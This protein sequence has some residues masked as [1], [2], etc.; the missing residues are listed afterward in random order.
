MRSISKYLPLFLLAGCGVMPQQQSINS[1][2]HTLS[3]GQIYIYGECHSDKDCLDR[4]L[5]L[6]KSFYQQGMRHLFI[7]ASFFRAEWLNEWMKKA[8]DD[9]LIQIHEDGKGTLNYS[10]NVCI[11]YQK[12]KEQ[13][14]ETVFHGFD[15]GH[16]YDTTGKRYLNHLA[17][18]GQSNSEAYRRVQE[19]IEQ[20]RRYY[21]SK[22]K[23]DDFYREEVMTQNFIKDFE[24]LNGESIM[25]ITG[26]LHLDCQGIDNYLDRSS[27]P[28]FCYSLLRRLK[29]YYGNAIHAENLTIP[30]GFTKK[31]IVHK[32]GLDFDAFYFGTYSLP[33]Y[34]A[35][36]FWQLG[37]AMAGFRNV[38]NTKEYLNGAQFPMKL[39]ENEIY[40]LKCTKSDDSVEELYYRSSYDVSKEKIV[41]YRLKIEP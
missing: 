12:I 3:R 25:A 31:S 1:T 37:G 4:E 16:Q 26:S 5:S 2:V 40:L 30:T 11:F 21:Q 23:S 6:W 13:C 15:V 38:P 20:G 24:A 18:L 39:Y 32:Y 8:N 28:R 27:D 29:E 19:N 41:A 22:K 36:E 34:K 33:P 14:P 9:I 7:E 10:L 17:S 35:V